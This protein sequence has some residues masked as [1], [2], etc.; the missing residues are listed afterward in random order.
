MSKFGMLSIAAATIALAIPAA[1]HAVILGPDAATCANGERGVIVNVTGFKQRTGKVRVQLY[2]AQSSFLDKGAWL[3]RVDVA[4]PRS[5]TAAICV[6]VSSPGK[7]VVSVR[8]DLNGNG[9]SDMKDGGGFS[10]NPDVKL[11]D[12]MRK[13]KPSLSETS[14]SVGESTARVNVVLNYVRGLS[15]EPVG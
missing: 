9:K 12:L 4:V 5:G 8:H 3:Q 13:R 7:Y 6:P 1:A 2:A 14:F 11:T 15:F 10:G